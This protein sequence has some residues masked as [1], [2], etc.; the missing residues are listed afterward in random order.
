M[1]PK[2]WVTEELQEGKDQYKDNTLQVHHVGRAGVG[3]VR[4]DLLAVHAVLAMETAYILLAFTRLRL[5]LDRVVIRC[6]WNI[7]RLRAT[8]MRSA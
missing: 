4:V 6:A 1:E 5:G 3:K 8:F 2:F 7:T